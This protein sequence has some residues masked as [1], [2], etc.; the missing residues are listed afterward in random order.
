MENKSH[1]PSKP[2]SE[3]TPEEIAEFRNSVDPNTMGF[4]GKE[5]VPSENK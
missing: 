1:V 3:M 5:G 2:I 4:D